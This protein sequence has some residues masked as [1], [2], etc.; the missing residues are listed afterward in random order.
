MNNVK[1]YLGNKKWLVKDLTIGIG[2]YS[3]FNI[4]NN[5]NTRSFKKTFEKLKDLEY[6]IS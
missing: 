4:H 1:G 5:N 2:L 3:N 6:K